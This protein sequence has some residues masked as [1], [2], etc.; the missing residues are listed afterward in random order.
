MSWR[1]VAE[2]VER[3]AKPSVPKKPKLTRNRAFQIPLYSRLKARNLYVGQMLDAAT[4]AEAT[5]LKVKQVYDIA[6]REGWSK[7]RAMVRAKASESAEARAQKDIDSLIEEVAADTAELSLG[8]LAK[9][10]VALERNDRDAA[11]DLQAYSQAAKN[12]VGLYRQAKNLDVANKAGESSTTVV[13][14]GQLVAASTASKVERNV[15][16]SPQSENSQVIDV[17][18]NP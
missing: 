1:M 3:E 2:A 8:T 17:S 15:T 7:A 10:K 14:V 16:P 13:F 5:G 18:A 6:S 4:V 9:S 12:F 11:K